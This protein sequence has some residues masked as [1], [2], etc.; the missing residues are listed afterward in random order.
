[1][2]AVAT[3]MQN[4]VA[5]L[6]SELGDQAGSLGQPAARMAGHIEALAA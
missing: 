2:P 5:G 1:M 4:S 6:A 3:E